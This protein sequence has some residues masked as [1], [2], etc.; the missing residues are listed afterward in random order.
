MHTHSNIAETEIPPYLCLEHKITI[1]GSSYY[2]VSIFQRKW[3]CLKV[4]PHS[5]SYLYTK[6]TAETDK[7]TKGQVLYL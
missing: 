7:V 5:I 3:K 4:P 6:Q 2:N 1:Y